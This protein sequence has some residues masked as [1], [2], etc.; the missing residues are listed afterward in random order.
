MIVLNRRHYRVTPL[1]MQ[2]FLDL[3]LFFSLAHFL[4]IESIGFY[5]FHQFCVLNTHLSVFEANF[6]QA[7]TKLSSPRMLSSTGWKTTGFN[8]RYW[9]LLAD[10]SA[11]RHICALGRLSMR[12]LIWAA[13]G[14][15]CGSSVN[16]PANFRF[17][18]RSRY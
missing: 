9:L 16:A 3:S 11:N 4:T 15:I 7:V 2:S 10:V 18:A 14:A 6:F 1:N 5:F 17:S 8:F 13:V 12:Y